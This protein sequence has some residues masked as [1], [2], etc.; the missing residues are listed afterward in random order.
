MYS[1]F[2]FFF[3][4][5]IVHWVKLQGFIESGLQLQIRNILNLF[6]ADLECLVKVHWNTLFIRFFYSIIFPLLLLDWG[7]IFLYF[8]LSFLT[9]AKPGNF[10]NKIKFIKNPLVLKNQ[11]RLYLKKKRLIL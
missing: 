5:V 1:H 3:N 7:A 10:T 4:S 9:K 11:S 2:F 6:L 8:P